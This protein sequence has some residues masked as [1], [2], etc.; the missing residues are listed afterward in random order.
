M[1]D[2]LNNQQNIKRGK[3]EELKEKKA[4]R[5]KVGEKTGHFKEKRGEKSFRCQMNRLEQSHVRHRD[6]Q[7]NQQWSKGKQ[8]S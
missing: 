8:D 7:H 1:K 6:T 3:E 4:E 5:R 2:I